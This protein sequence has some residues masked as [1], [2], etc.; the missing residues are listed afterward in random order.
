MN[1]LPLLITLLFLFPGMAQAEITARTSAGAAISVMAPLPQPPNENPHPPQSPA[2]QRRVDFAVQE[3]RAYYGPNVEIRHPHVIPWSWERFQK[4]QGSSMVQPQDRGNPN[5]IVEAQTTQV[6]MP[7]PAEKP[8]PPGG[9]MPAP[10]LQ[11]DEF[12]VHAYAK[13]PQD[14]RWYHLDVILSEDSS[15]HLTRRNFY[16]VPMPPVPSQLPPGVVC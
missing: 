4:N 15:G 10:N 1:K 13:F 2:E 5:V 11:P 16:V 14:P 12:M 9:M 7:P 6:D 8:L 3:I